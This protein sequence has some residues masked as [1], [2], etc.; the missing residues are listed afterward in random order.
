[1]IIGYSYP[2]IRKYSIL[3]SYVSAL[4]GQQEDAKGCRPGHV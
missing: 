4:L 2:K 3:E 1:M